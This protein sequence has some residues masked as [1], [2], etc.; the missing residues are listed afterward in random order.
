M[1]NKIKI[2]V[3]VNAFNIFK[4]KVPPFFFDGDFRQEKIF[5]KIFYYV[6]IKF[7]T[8]NHFFDD[9][10]FRFNCTFC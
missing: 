10:F 6:F 3:K 4:F 2:R 9:F 5:K 8:L 7:K 1:L